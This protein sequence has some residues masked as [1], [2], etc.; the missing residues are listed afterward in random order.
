MPGYKAVPIECMCET[1]LQTNAE[2]IHSPYSIN[3]VWNSNEKSLNIDVSSNKVSYLYFMI[4]L[5]NAAHMGL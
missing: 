1:Y 3:Y 5:F 4:D 2:H